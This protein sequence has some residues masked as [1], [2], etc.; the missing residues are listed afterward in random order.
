MKKSHVVIGGI[1]TMAISAALVGGYKVWRNILKQKTY[2]FNLMLGPNGESTF[3]YQENDRWIPVTIENYGKFKN[4]LTNKIDTYKE[5]ILKIYF[6]QNVL[7]VKV[8]T[9]DDYKKLEQEAIDYVD[10]ILEFIGVP[11]KSLM[12]ETATHEVVEQ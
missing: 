1:S 5:V 12:L 3:S 8:K 6:T 4:I 7:D 2:Y 10:Q 9:Q 11:P